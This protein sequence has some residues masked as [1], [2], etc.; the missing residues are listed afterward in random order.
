[1][2]LVEAIIAVAIFS[3]GMAGFTFL[4]SGVW[5]NNAYT[6]ELGKASFGASRGVNK[7]AGYVRKARQGDDGAY[8]I[9]SASGDDLVLFSDYDKDGI[10]ERLHF[11]KA[12]NQLLMGYRKPSAGLPKTYASGDEGV[13]VIVDNLVNESSVPVF[14]YY[15]KNYS[16][17]SASNPMTGLIYVW[18][19]RLIKILVKINIEKGVANDNVELRSFV[20]LRNLNDYSRLTS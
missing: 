3:I 1:M 13:E 12:G 11:Y 17:D 19:V 8:P 2:S 4:F 7:V 5:K 6:Y 9:K 18:D 20:E 14:Y 16:G 15:D 10:A